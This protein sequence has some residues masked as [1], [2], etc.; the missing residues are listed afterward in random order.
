MSESVTLLKKRET[1]KDNNISCCKNYRPQRIRSKG[2]ILCLFVRLL[3]EISNE[4]TLFATAVTAITMF[5]SKII[6][7]LAPSLQLFSPIVGWIADAWFGRYQVIKVSTYISLVSNILAV[8]AAYISYT[9]T[10]ILNHNAFEVLVYIFLSISMCGTAAFTAN[11]IQFSLD[12][13]IGATGDEL[14][15]VIQWNLW[16]SYFAY[17]IFSIWTFSM[18]NLLLLAG[19]TLYTT[20]PISIVFSIATTLVFYIGKHWL[21]T[22]HRVTN[23]IK[24][25]AQVLNYARKNKY[26]RNR[27]SLT[28]WEED[29]P[30][31]LDLG[32]EKY[33]GP[34]SEEEVEDVR[35]ILQLTPLLLC[36]ILYKLLAGRMEQWFNYMIPNNVSMSLRWI[37]IAAPILAFTVLIPVFHFIIHPFFYKYLPS[38]LKAIGTGAFM[39]FLSFIVQI[40]LDIVIH[41]ESEEPQQCVYKNDTVILPIDY[42]WIILQGTLYSVGSVILVVS[43]MQFG[44]AQ[45]PEKMKGLTIGLNYLFV[46]IGYFIGFHIQKAFKKIPSIKW[47]SCELYIDIAELIL[48]SAIL[49]IF[50]VLAKRYQLR[51]RER[52]INVYLITE[53]HY[54]RYLDQEEE[55]QREHELSYGSISSTD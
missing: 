25:I 17:C 2:A 4:A 7:Y 27:S 50:L 42:R 32:K 10:S 3:L 20:V 37:I 53:D 21:D 31:R 49:I 33:G 46:G 51:I 5:E 12:Q 11:I 6:T 15:A 13:C 40:A 35:T 1:N 16:T 48:I 24:L 18:S 30:S 26:P 45:T 44:V 38:M 22:T 23:P 36:A 39:L 8:S 54:E 9:S 19:Y 29:Y 52:T 43:L 41:T 14:S 34:F 47:L 28:F 55:Y